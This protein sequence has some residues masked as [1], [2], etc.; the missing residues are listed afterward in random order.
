MLI[1]N[2]NYLMGVEELDND[3][4]HMFQIAE[5]ILNRVR[6]RSD[7]PAMRIFIIRE[8]LKYLHGYFFRHAAQEEAYMRKI[9]YEGYALHKMQHDDFQKI[10]MAKYQKI[11]ASG[12]CSKEDVW[13]FI[14]SGVGWLLEHIATADMAIVGKGVLQKTVAADASVATLE[15]EINL[16]C[17]ATLNIN[18]YVKV[19]NTNYT[20]ESFGKAVCQKIVYEKDGQ[21]TTVISGVERSFILYVAKMLYGGSVEDEMDLILSTLEV[22][23][24]QFWITLSR[25]LT[26]S[27]SM[28]TIKENHFIMGGTLQEELQKL[29]PAISVLFT[30]G[31][32][33][34]FLS[35]SSKQLFQPQNQ[36]AEM[37]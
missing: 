23:G 22:F 27:S 3:H 35:S 28:I 33:Q 13:D 21:E 7:D 5:Q 36:N 17:I 37:E 29:E 26:G 19:V 6:E 20:G 15:N 12:T 8:G 34:F 16:L 24:A 10:Q 1:W 30:S 11:V 18:A 32:G 9:G 2:E 4:R 31:K 14:G 25:Q